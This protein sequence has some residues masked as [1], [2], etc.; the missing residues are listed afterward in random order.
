M[1]FQ[2]YIKTKMLKK[3]ER[4]QI[5][6]DV[7]ILLMLNAKNCCALNAGHFFPVF[8][9]IA[10]EDTAVEEFAN[11]MYVF[12]IFFLCYPFVMTF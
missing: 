10:V 9:K 11:E 4:I 5:T 8:S 1:K 12:F 6:E 7:F 3:N 2:L